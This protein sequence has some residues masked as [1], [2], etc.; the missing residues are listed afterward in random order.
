VVMFS[1]N[2]ILK[3]IV[4]VF[5]T[6][7][8]PVINLFDPSILRMYALY[9]VTQS[10]FLL[11]AIYF[12]R[13]NFLKTVLSLFAI[14][15]VIAIYS[16]LTARLIVFHN[17]QSIHFDNSMPENW[18]NFFENTFAPVINALFWYCLAPFFFVVSYFSLKERQV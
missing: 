10:V 3:S 9:M 5:S 7:Q 2:I 4:A 8:V 1:I 14:C 12:R 13:V 11:G 17:F 16:S 15:I 18:Q 6:N